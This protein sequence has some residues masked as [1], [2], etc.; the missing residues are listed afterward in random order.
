MASFF[1]SCRR[2]RPRQLRAPQEQLKG[3][4]KFTMKQ[5]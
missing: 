2:M 4:S 3:S 5:P 1:Q